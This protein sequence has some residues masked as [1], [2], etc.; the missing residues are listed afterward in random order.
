MKKKIIFGVILLCILFVVADYCELLGGGLYKD[1]Y[2]SVP[3]RFQFF[4]IGDNPVNNVKVTTL[5]NG[6]DF[7]NNYEYA[8]DNTSVIVGRLDFSAGWKET[9]FFKKPN[10]YRMI[11]NNEV[12]FVF[13]HPDYLEQKKVLLLKNLNSL[14][15]IVLQP[16]EQMN[17]KD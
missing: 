5:L 8:D 10:P 3:F 1:A 2:I 11:K 7:R 16:K 12:E 13:Q 14:Y 17:E 9:L 15:K 6:Q 4:D